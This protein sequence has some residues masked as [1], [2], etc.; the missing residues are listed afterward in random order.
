[1]KYYVFLKKKYL[2]VKLCPKYFCHY[3]NDR[4]KHHNS[5]RKKDNSWDRTM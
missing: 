2:F 1:M 4:T 5:T 3:R